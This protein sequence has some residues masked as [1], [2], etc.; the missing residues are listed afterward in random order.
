MAVTGHCYAAIYMHSNI[1]VVKSESRAMSGGAPSFVVDLCQAAFRP[2]DDT[3]MEAAIN[4]V[5]AYIE[6]PDVKGSRDWP[7]ETVWAVLD[8]PRTSLPDIGIAPSILLRAALR[9]KSTSAE[10]RCT[11][12]RAYDQG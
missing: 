12:S 5:V 2:A 3:C 10:I 4:T 9:A 7:L 11:L 1:D 8:S 6:G